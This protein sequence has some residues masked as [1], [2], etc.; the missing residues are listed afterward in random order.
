MPTLEEMLDHFA[1]GLSDIKFELPPGMC[2]CHGE[3]PAQGA[4]NASIHEECAKL[5]G[6]ST[7]PAFERML[8][9][10]ARAL[11][12]RRHGHV[13]I[14]GQR[15]VGKTALMFEALRRMAVGEKPFAGIMVVLQRHGSP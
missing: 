3:P 9:A 13:L 6:A 5:R 10:V 8:E 1:R 11:A 12:R 4:E 15:G 2:N 7:C 14:T